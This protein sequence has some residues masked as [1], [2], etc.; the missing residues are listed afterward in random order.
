MSFIYA[1]DVFIGSLSG[2]STY[3]VRTLSRAVQIFPG[4]SDHHTR[5]FCCSVNAHEE[6]GVFDRTAFWHQWNAY[7][8]AN[9]RFV[10]AKPKPGLSKTTPSA[11]K[12]EVKEDS[13]DAKPNPSSDSVTGSTNKTEVANQSVSKNDEKTATPND[14]S[15]KENESLEP[16]ASTESSSIRTAVAE[17]M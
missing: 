4:L 11:S 10:E 7:R 14:V 2:L 8:L 9:E 5:A 3:T 12:M 6:T 1:A 17:E 16:R 13:V 15:T